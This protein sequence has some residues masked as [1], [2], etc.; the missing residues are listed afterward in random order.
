MFRGGGGAIVLGQG[1]CGYVWVLR[2]AG[3]SSIAVT[4]PPTACACMHVCVC[5]FVG[6]AVCS[7]GTTLGSEPVSL[8]V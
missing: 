4:G 8:T 6:V 3:L 2:L 7:C 1:G 5:G